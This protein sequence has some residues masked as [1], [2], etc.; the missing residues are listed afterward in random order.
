[1]SQLT[2]YNFLKRKKDKWFTTKQ[3]SIALKNGSVSLSLKQLY[4][5]GEIRRKA[6]SSSSTGTKNDIWRARGSLGYA[7]RFKD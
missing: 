7:W 3:I 5:Y 2:V 6:S 1:M 4:K